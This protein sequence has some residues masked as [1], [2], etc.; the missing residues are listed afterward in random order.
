ML[1][2]QTQ[3]GSRNEANGKAGQVREVR[4]FLPQASRGATPAPSV[5][6]IGPGIVNEWDIDWVTVVED[7]EV[8]YKHLPLTGSWEFEDRTLCLQCGEYNA[9]PGHVHCESCTNLYQS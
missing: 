9:L 6:F 8:E 1:Q 4:V 3:D 7:P 5:H 2:V